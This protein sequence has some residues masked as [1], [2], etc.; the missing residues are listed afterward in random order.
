M[1]RVLGRK[2]RDRRS[3]ISGFLSVLLLFTLLMI[4]RQQTKKWEILSPLNLSQYAPRS[5]A[6]E[7]C[8]K[9]PKEER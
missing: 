4:L 9:F 2:R 6:F 7:K 1:C 8:R 5:I 3:R